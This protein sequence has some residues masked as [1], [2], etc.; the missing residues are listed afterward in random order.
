[1]FFEKEDHSVWRKKSEGKLGSVVFIS[2]VQIDLCLDF[3]PSMNLAMH[4]ESYDRCTNV[5]WY[6]LVRIVQR[7]VIFAHNRRCRFLREM[8]VYVPWQ[9]RIY[10]S[11]ENNPKEL[12]KWIDKH[13]EDH[14]LMNRLS[15]R[16]QNT[17]L[18]NDRIHVLLLTCLQLFRLRCDSLSQRVNEEISASFT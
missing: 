5:E 14:R 13:R 11:I 1:M 2:L 8:V 6:C 9:R 15:E 12:V 4:W 16:Q 7:R 10:L 3:V 17:V 18:F